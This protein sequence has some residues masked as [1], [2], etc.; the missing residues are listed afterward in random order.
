M[1]DHVPLLSSGAWAILQV[2]PPSMVRIRGLPGW[3]LA[4]TAVIEDAACNVD[5][6]GYP[7]GP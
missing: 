6:L 1:T 7:F 4:A 2:A 3:S 5:A